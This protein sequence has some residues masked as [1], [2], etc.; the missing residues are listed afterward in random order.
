MS[1]DILG[2]S[3]EEWIKS[4]PLIANMIKLKELIWINSRY[5]PFEIVVKNLTIGVD[6]VQDA[7]QRL[8][9]FAPFI[10][11]HFPETESSSGIIESPLIE[12]NE[13]KKKLNQLGNIDI[14]GK[15]LLKKDS[16]LQIAGSI[17][18]RGGIYEVLAH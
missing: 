17:K 1:E 18:A 7:E 15:L 14:Q 4:Y 10:I 13:M 16:H 2:Y 12:I 5:A 9:R 3:S 8:N 11:R 6:D